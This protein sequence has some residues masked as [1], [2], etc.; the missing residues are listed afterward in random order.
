MCKYVRQM[1]EASEVRYKLGLT[2]PY[3]DVIII[4]NVVINM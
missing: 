3:L 2:V 4:S 1:N